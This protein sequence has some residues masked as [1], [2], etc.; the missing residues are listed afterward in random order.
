MATDGVRIGEFARRHGLTSDAVR[1]YERLGLLAAP[2]RTARGYRLYGPEDDVR[3]RFVLRAKALG[4][5][6]NE[7]ADVLRAGEEAGPQT[8][9]PHL[10][11]LLLRKAE[12]ARRQAR[13]TEDFADHLMYVHDGLCE[14][15]TDCA[16]GCSCCDPGGGAA[17]V[18]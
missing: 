14:G 2:T 12:D 3:L 18:G 11:A 16:C 6:L 5:S 13:E 8:V 10:Q 7:I 1:F 4:L 17:S 9:R 15:P